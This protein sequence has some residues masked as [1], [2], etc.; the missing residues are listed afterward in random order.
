MSGLSS[1]VRVLRA[2]PAERQAE[3][4]ES[5]EQPTDGFSSVYAARH[6]A[7]LRRHIF[8]GESSATVSR[9]LQMQD[10][11]FYAERRYALQRAAE[12]LG[13]ASKP[14]NAFHPKERRVQTLLAHARSHFGFGLAER[15]LRTL[16]DVSEG[17]LDAHQRLETILLTANV[18]DDLGRLDELPHL[19]DRAQAWLADTADDS[20]DRRLAQIAVDVT[21]AYLCWIRNDGAGFTNRWNMASKSLRELC[22]EGDRIAAKLLCDCWN[23][24]TYCVVTNGNWNEAQRGL[25][26]AQDLARRFD[27]SRGIEAELRVNRAL[28]YLQDPATASLASAELDVAY[29][30]AIEHALPRTVWLCLTTDFSESL[31]RQDHTRALQ[32]ATALFECVNACE[33]VMW[34]RQGAWILIDAYMAVDRVEDANRVAMLDNELTHP[35]FDL[36]HCVMLL[37]QGHYREGYNGASKILDQFDNLSLVRLRAKTLLVRAQAAHGMGNWGPA[38]S[39]VEEAIAIYERHRT[40]VFN[41]RS[42]Y[43]VAH[44]ITGQKTYRNLAADLAPSLAAALPNVRSAARGVRLTKRQTEIAW[45]AAEGATSPEIAERLGI[46]PRTVENHLDAVFTYFGIH[47]VRARQH[48]V[49]ALHAYKAQRR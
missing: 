39:D 8:G 31:Y 46:S 23:F 12:L 44:A 15:A 29:G 49:D 18:L 19:A 30:L 11:Q 2:L 5:I 32:S 24:L 10:R 16:R 40:Q 48:L 33:G 41:L 27:L 14:M 6:A 7:I 13:V 26:E 43:H 9:A 45:L 28:L 42:A 1:L 3:L 38:R 35:Y 4:H 47:G 22:D 37:K 20:L 34:K 21:L 36:G 17:T 25:R